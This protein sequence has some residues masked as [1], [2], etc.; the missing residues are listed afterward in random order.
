MFPGLQ[1]ERSSGHCTTV[2]WASAWL[3]AWP[4]WKIDVQINGTRS[5]SDLDEGGGSRRPGL[6]RQHGQPGG[7]VD[8]R[9]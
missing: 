6:Y 2:S 5:S 8:R 4:R 1:H 9:S 7:G 3:S